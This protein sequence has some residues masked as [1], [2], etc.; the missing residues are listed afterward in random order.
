MLKSTSEGSDAFS[1]A[2]QAPS[3]AP[4]LPAQPHFGALVISLDFEIH[5]GVRDIYSVCGSYRQHMLGVRQAIPQIL[6]LFEAYDIGATWATVG[7]LFASSRQQLEAFYPKL[8]PEYEDRAL[9]PY[10]EV[11]GDDE[12]ADPFHFAPTLIAGIAKRS[13][14]EIGTHTFSHYY[15]LERGQ[16]R[17]TFKA[18][19]ES[20]IAIAGAYGYQIRSIVFPRNQINPEYAEQL[21]EVGID[22]YRGTE[23]GWIYRPASAK[24]ER[25]LHIYAARWLDRYINLSG[26]HLSD[27]NHIWQS[28]GLCNIPSSRF[29]RPYARRWKYLEPLLVRRIVDAMHAAATSNKIFHLWWHPHNFG[30]NTTENIAVL[31]N[32]LTA[33][34]RFRTLYG[35]RSLTMSEAAT[36]A[37][38]SAASN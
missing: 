8:R 36:F 15:C 28:N 33:F 1:Q 13:R 22:C 34:A 23:Q 25:K 14:Q 31:K 19:L 32:I 12:V 9:D 10:Q 7:C 24:A 4:M 29:L 35:M 18:D 17:E 37:K 38:A 16:N 3:A 21:L 20:A 26:H 27:W 6:D 2:T 5:W 11:V 30:M